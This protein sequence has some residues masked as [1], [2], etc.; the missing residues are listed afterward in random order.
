MDLPAL[1]DEVVPPRHG[2]SLEDPWTGAESS[3][4]PA[5]PAHTNISVGICQVPANDM[6]PTLILE[7]CDKLVKLV[8]TSTRFA[9]G[10]T[11]SHPAG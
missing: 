7:Q 8:H 2:R 6:V 10:E 4:S 1:S 3:K 5:A 9:P 11:V